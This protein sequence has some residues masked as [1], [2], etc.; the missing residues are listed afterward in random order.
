MIALAGDGVERRTAVAV[1]ATYVVGFRSAL[2][3]GPL[4]PRYAPPSSGTSD[5]VSALADGPDAAAAAAWHAA[6]RAE[7]RT[8]LAM[9]ASLHEDA[10][11]VKYTL[12]CFDAAAADP[13]SEQLYMAAAAS[14]AGWW[15]QHPKG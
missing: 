8:K 3:T 7:L 9:Q 10:H 6:D 13:E 1:A 12:A 2:G 5:L 15:A 4:V 11:L 14:L